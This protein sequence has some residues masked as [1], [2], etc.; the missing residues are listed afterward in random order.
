MEL[1][2]E[3]FQNTNSGNFLQVE[4]NKKKCPEHLH[5][6]K[7]RTVTKEDTTGET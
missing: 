4:K 7:V 3:I 5:V 6:E 1:C 2:Y